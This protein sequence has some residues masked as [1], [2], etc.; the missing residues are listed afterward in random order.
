MLIVP[1]IDIMDGKVVRL[2]R[3]DFNRAKVYG[4]S[5]LEYAKKWQTEGASIIH[6]VDLD[7][8]KTGE[9]KN[10]SVIRDIIG[11][12]S[13]KVEVGGGIR[14]EETIKKY[15]DVGAARVV[16]STKVIEDQSFLLTESI[17]AYLNKVAVSI[18]IKHMESPEVITSGTSGWQQSGDIL[19]DIPSF[20]N[21]VSSVGV[22]FVNFSDISKDG[23]MMGPDAAK[24]LIFLKRARKAAA[25]K[26]FFTYA[27]GISSLD[28]IRVLGRLGD[29]GV[30]AVIV[31]R[32]LYENKFSL[33]EAIGIVNNAD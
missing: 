3:G 18:D 15:L 23:M 25:T 27:G 21:A 17:S 4:L 6:V 28:D 11:G 16:L 12:V 26:L 13:V 22:K 7:G 29:D 31:G 9:P 10:F 32:A 1:A 2:E 33:K 24:I 19:I 30:D 14:T 8:A 5:A 20:I